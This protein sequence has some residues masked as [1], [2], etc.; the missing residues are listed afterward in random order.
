[1]IEIKRRYGIWEAYVNGDLFH[2]SGD[3]DSLLDYLVWNVEKIKDE[4]INSHTELE[5]LQQ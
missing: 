5:C 3:L 2:Y 4:F 1:M